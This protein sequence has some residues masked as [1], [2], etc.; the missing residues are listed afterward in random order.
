MKKSRMTTMRGYK[1]KLSSDVR[2]E[3]ERKTKEDEERRETERTG[4]CKERK[5][6]RKKKNTN[7]NH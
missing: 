7:T 5:G 4:N 6:P 2:L 1:L 3:N